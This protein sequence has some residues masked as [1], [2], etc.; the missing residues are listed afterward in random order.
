QGA[1]VAMDGSGAVRAMVGGHDYANSQFDRASEGR[2]QPGSA[3]K[4]FV[5]L[6]ALE[7]GR[8]PHSIRNDAPVRIGR[9]KPE[10][11]G[12]KYYGN[13]TLGE[14]LARSLNSVAAQLVQEVGPKTVVETA[15]RLG[16]RS[17]LQANASLALGTSETSLLE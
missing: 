15:E 11:H 16:I 12:G 13:V 17:N 14:A 3:F 8:T 7:Q 2:R 4:P 5:F 10:N 6:A 1:L 9:W